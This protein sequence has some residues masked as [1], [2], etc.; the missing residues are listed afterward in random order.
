MVGMQFLLTTSLGIV[1]LL[2]AAYPYT[3][4]KIQSIGYSQIQ[5]VRK[6]I[7][8][9]ENNEINTKSLLIFLSKY[10]I[11]RFWIVSP[12]VGYWSGMIGLG[13]LFTHTISERL[14]SD[15]DPITEF[16]YQSSM[17][18]LFVCVLLFLLILH[19]FASLTSETEMDKE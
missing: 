8:K 7:T 5:L 15:I 10:I 19:R 12:S 16:L 4:P 14:A 18:L 6:N 3:T 2:F 1:A 13:L 9:I 11:G 17:F